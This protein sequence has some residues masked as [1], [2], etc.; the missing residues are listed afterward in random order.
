MA[1]HEFTLQELMALDGGRVPQAWK[2]AVARCA[3]DCNDRPALNKPRKVTLELELVPMCD[4]QGQLES[5]QADFS[6]KDQ[7]P[8]RQTKT[9]SLGYRNIRSPKGIESA[10]LVFN[11]MSVENVNQAAFDFEDGKES[12]GGGGE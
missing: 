9:Y 10:Q 7:A 12:E 8:A 1:L 2:Q 6:I 5:I 3:M 11:D 4:H